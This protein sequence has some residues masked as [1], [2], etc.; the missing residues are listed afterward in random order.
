MNS[1]D[2]KIVLELAFEAGLK[3]GNDIEM[4]NSLTDFED[5]YRININE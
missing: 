2:L 4:N 5:W 3:L 1:K